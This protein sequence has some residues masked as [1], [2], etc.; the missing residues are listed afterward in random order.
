[1]PLTPNPPVNTGTAP[2]VDR[3][4]PCDPPGTRDAAGW[5][6]TDAGNSD[7]W[8]RIDDVDGGE[9]AGWMQC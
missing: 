1:M 5:T 6:K 8:D 9:A 3:P 7:G 2:D 4:M